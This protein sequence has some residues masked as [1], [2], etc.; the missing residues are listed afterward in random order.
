MKRI[1]FIIS[2]ISGLLYACSSGKY[3]DEF[4]K[5]KR[6]IDTLEILPIDLQIKTVDF[7]RRQQSDP[8][9][10]E[11]VITD[12]INQTNSVLNKKYKIVKPD[13][14]DLT[15]SQ[16]SVDFEQLSNLLDDKK[17]SLNNVDIPLSFNNLK[18]NH[19][20]QYS[21]MLIIR[22]QYC[23]NY[24]EQTN[25]IWIDPLVKTYIKQCIFLIDNFNG[26]ILYYKKI[27]TA[28]D[29]SVKLA[30]EQITLKSLRNLYYK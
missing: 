27:K 21:I 26:K 16:V 3:V 28:G 11:I 7:Y 18:R 17:N 20:H 30:V 24:P 25:K 5:I 12:I 10:E 14:N 2:V 1:L 6:S 23:I 19:K 13:Y 9:L 22:A 15:D 8:Q 4:K 29:I